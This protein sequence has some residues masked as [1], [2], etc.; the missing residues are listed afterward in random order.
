MLQ[1]LHLPGIMINHKINDSRIL[2]LFCFLK[3]MIIKLLHLYLL[4]AIII[5]IFFD[6]FINFNART[7]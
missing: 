5:Q 2:R 6:L 4:Y 1:L 3:S 7:I